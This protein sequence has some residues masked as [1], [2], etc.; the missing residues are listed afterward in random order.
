M[1]EIREWLDHHRFEPDV[2]QHRMA[3]DHV[4]IRIDF[5]NG[6]EAVAFSEAFG[7]TLLNVK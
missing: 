4:L 3:A 6:S 5:K 2:F 7:G 1:A